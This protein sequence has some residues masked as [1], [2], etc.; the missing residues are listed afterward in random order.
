MY[1]ET[2]RGQLKQED[3]GGGG[4]RIGTDLLQLLL[5]P[6]RD[7]HFCAILD[8]GGGD[9]G[10]NARASTCNDGYTHEDKAS[11]GE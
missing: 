7:V 5:L 11:R 8:E 6:R 1:Q 9:H 4:G 10:T 3:G 2:T